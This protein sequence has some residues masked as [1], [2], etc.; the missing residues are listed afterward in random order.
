VAPFFEAVQ[1][2]L[3]MVL[4]SPNGLLITADHVGHAVQNDDP[5]LVVNV[6]RHVIDHPAPQSK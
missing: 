5:A 6:I 4:S 1:R 3:E 2:D